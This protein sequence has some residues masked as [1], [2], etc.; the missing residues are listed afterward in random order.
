VTRSYALIIGAMK[1]GTTSL[2][3]HLSGHPQ[4]SS[5]RIGEPNF[6]VDDSV[7]SKGFDWYESLFPYDAGK[8]RICL[9][10]SG[11]YTKDPFFP[12]PAER[13]A[14]DL[15]NPRF[16]YIVRDPVDRVV[17]HFNY[18]LRYGWIDA[19]EKPTDDRFL[20]PSRYA[21]QLECF[22]RFFPKESI[23]VVRLEDMAR[24]PQSVLA[25]VQSFLGLDV[26]PLERV[27]KRHNVGRP[28]TQLQYLTWRLG[29]KPYV[30]RLKPYLPPLLRKAARQA[31]SA[32]AKQIALSPAERVAVAERLEQ[33]AL[34]LRERYGVDPRGKA[35]PL[36]ERE[37]AT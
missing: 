15:D 8:H 16:V 35:W 9:E 30:Q 11:N 5:C 1:C 3:Q 32:P 26:Q 20:S 34:A 7:Y 28:S 31:G 24:D 29:L 22:E 33:D 6:F 14:K 36:R 25:Q 18:S 21:A 19:G 27:D 4:I 2:T 12:S 13:I 10:N 23:L 37:L 17:S